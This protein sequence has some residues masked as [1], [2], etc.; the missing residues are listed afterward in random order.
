M[1]IHMYMCTSMCGCVL[2][3]VCVLLVCCTCYV[4]IGIVKVVDPLHMHLWNEHYNN[5]TRT[6]GLLTFYL[7]AQKDNSVVKVSVA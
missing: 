4:P 2:V 5:L 6:A 3:H 7:Q 1:L